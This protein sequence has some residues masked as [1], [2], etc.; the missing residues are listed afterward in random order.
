MQTVFILKTM[1]YKS[2]KSTAHGFEK[3]T[4]GVNEFHYECFM[5][6]SKGITTSQ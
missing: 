3:V 6:L 2:A 1:A 4:L 5:F